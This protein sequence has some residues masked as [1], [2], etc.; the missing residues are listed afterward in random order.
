[1]PSTEVELG[2]GPRGGD[3]EDHIQRQ[4]DGRGDQGQL[5]GGEGGTV[6]EAFE[7]GAESL[8]QGLGEDGRQRQEEKEQEK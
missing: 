6:I 2:Q 5:D 8:A 3:A 1:L 7:V 4:R